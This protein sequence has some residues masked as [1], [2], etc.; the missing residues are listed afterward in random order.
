MPKV[1]PTEE[2]KNL[3]LP[4]SDVYK[5]THMFYHDDLHKN[6][7]IICLN[8]EAMKAFMDSIFIANRH[9]ITTENA[10]VRQWWEQEELQM[11]RPFPWP[12]ATHHFMEYVN[13]ENFKIAAAFELHL[14]ARLIS[15]DYIVHKL[16]NSSAIY[17]SLANEQKNR[18]ITKQEFLAISSFHFDG[19]HNFLPGLKDNSLDFLTITEKP[20]YQK[21]LGLSNEQINII[22]DYRLLRNQLHLPGDI[23]ETPNINNYSKPIIEFLVEFINTEIVAWSNYL[24]AKY[25]INLK[26][27][28]VLT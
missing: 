11:I 8:L 5:R 12:A 23:V 17:K 13:Y 4:S 25:D 2:A 7:A 22:N 14:K 1:I 20:N 15:M 9:L 16:D 26:P 21:A 27:F 19:H 6:H 28:N 3:L 24:I 18:P 10:A